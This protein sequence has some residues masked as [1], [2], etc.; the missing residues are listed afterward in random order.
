MPEDYGLRLD[1]T[2]KGPGFLGAL[3][4]PAD[5]VSTELSIGVNLEGGPEIQIP[6]L[7]P[8]LTQDEIDFLLAG[9]DPTTDII[10]K[11]VDHA[12]KRKRKGLSPFKTDKRQQ[13]IDILNNANPPKLVNEG[14][15]EIVM[16]Q[17]E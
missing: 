1:G 11:A 14:T 16:E 4:R 15:I 10:D 6:M 3:E 8:T 9:N 5:G 2:P 17:L 12:M 7:V 13:A